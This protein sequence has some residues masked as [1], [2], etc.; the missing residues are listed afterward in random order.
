MQH[1]RWDKSDI[2]YLSQT[3][4]TYCVLAA[5]TLTVTK[6]NLNN[7][8]KLSKIKLDKTAKSG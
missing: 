1:V 5:K 7:V 3:V 4:G 2:L 6:N 8:D